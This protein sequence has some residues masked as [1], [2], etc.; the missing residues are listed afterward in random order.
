MLVVVAKLQAK[1]GE[2]EK[3]EKAFLDVLPKV[4]EE[5]GT[6]AYT[7]N[8]SQADPNVLMVLEKYKDMD[9][10]AA[11]GATPH[12]AELFGIITPLLEGDLSLDMY[13]E[14]A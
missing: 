4:R 1:A 13:E 7:I 10:F 12:L 3:V 14:I 8:R 9:A 11:H 2:V 6:V 5:E